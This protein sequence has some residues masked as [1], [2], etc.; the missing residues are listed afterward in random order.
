[1]TGPPLAERWDTVRGLRM[2]SLVVGDPEGAVVVL[3]HGLGMASESMADMAV[4]LPPTYRVYAP[5]LP[6]FGASDHPPR[7]LSIRGLAD[8]LDRWCEA[9]GIRDA[10]VVG[11][12]YGAQ[13]V[14][15]LAA[16][17]V[18]AGRA[19]RRAGVLVLIGPTCDP[20]ARSLTGQVT[21]WVSNS[22]GDPG[23][24]DPMGLIKPYLKA[25]LLRV[26][27]TAWSATRHRI[28]DR[29]PLV[30]VPVLI[31]AGDLDRISPLPWTERLTELAARGE[32]RIVEGGAHSMHGS[33]PDRLAH[34]VDRF[35][36]ERDLVVAG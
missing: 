35:A 34:L 4:H 30:D 6:G 5:D 19:G 16:R 3:V 17:E 10:I 7:A 1:M 32:R 9:A 8:A 13:V 14:V 36:R 31:L 11:N 26:A 12:S 20:P 33:H 27:K 28:E 15:E 18:E 24:G 25:G 21:R 29:L 22:G 23:G 2:R